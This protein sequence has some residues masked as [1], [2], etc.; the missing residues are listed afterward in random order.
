MIEWGRLDN[1]DEVSVSDLAKATFTPTERKQLRQGVH[2]DIVPDGFVIERQ[3][4]WQQPNLPPIQ[5]IRCET[6][7]TDGKMMYVK[8]FLYNPWAICI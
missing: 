6:S 5:K 4:L 3:V 1:Y 7:F 8:P 2:Y